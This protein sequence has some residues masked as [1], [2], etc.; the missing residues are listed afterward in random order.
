MN[1]QLFTKPFLFVLG[2]TIA[3]GFIAFL[4]INNLNSRESSGF[5]VSEKCKKLEISTDTNSLLKKVCLEIP[6]L[7]KVDDFQATSLLRDYFHREVA[8]FGNTEIFRKLPSL[9]FQ[10]SYKD[11]SEYYELFT[12]GT[13]GALCGATADGLVTL[14][15]EFGLQATT[16]NF[17]EN[18]GSHVVTLVKLK[19]I[20]YLQDAYF[21][22]TVTNL[23]G[24][25]IPAR[26]LKVLIKRNSTQIEAMVG[27][28]LMFLATGV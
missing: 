17:G 21:N 16:Y 19:N 1:S 23:S 12:S 14:Y 13:K 7:T 5:L 6:T 27:S 2:G 28:G 26:D 22:Y 15:R 10:K 20:N 4:A 8:V 11:Y 3:A 25:P 18:P 24:E 9:E